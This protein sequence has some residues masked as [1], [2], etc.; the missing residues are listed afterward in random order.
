REERGEQGGRAYSMAESDGSS[1]EMSDDALQKLVSRLV[2]VGGELGGEGVDTTAEPQ[3]PGHARAL[4]MG[5]TSAQAAAPSDYADSSGDEEL[6]SAATGQPIWPSLAQDQ[7]SP[8]QAP[9]RTFSPRADGYD[10]EADL[11]ES[12]HASDD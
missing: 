11:L 5:A 7:P 12:A 6:V 3:S 4:I 1:S 10:R 8:I 2:E 9:R